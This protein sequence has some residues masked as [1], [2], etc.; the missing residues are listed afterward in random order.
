MLK[1]KRDLGLLS[2][3]QGIEKYLDEDLVP[4]AINCCY[5][6]AWCLFEAL[7]GMAYMKYECI[8]APAPRAGVASCGIRGWGG[9]RLATRAGVASCGIRGLGGSRLKHFRAEHGNCLRH[10][11]AEHAHTDH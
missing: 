6:V 9:A 11:R 3:L 1:R 5:C 2:M 10:F 8:A 7:I 4:A